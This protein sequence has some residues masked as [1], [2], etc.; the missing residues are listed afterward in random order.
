M[1][2]VMPLSALVANDTTNVTIPYSGADVNMNL[3][4]IA[5]LVR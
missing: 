4:Q 2:E 1:L 5:G 3:C